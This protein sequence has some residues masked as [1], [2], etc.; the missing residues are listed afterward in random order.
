MFGGK[1]RPGKNVLRADRF[2]DIGG[3]FLAQGL[4]GDNAGENGGLS[5]GG[6]LRMMYDN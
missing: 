6:L 1:P 2:L 3:D 5:W 4:S